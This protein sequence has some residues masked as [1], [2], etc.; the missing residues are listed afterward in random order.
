MAITS[1]IHHYPIGLFASPQHFIAIPHLNGKR[2]SRMSTIDRQQ[3]AGH[4]LTD[5]TDVIQP[6]LQLQANSTLVH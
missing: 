4:S 6:R 5:V 3:C 2:H 1:S